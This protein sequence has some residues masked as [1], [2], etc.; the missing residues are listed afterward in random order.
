MAGIR[1]RTAEWLDLPPDVLMDVPRV[2]VVG[3]L[4]VHIT[5]HRGLERF[6]PRLVLVRLPGAAAAVAVEGRNLTIGWITREE[7]LVTGL[8]HHLR[9]VEASL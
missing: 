5:N 9:F 1:Q 4:Q 2:E 8:I 7:L 3:H 6:G